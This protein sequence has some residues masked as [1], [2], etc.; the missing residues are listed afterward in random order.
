MF[1]KI[2][3]F[4]LRPFANPL[5]YGALKVMKRLRR[6]DDPRPA[7]AAA[8][9]LLHTLVIPWVFDL[10]HDD[11]FRTLARFAKLP[12]LEHDRILNEIEVAGICVPVFYLRAVKSLVRLEDYHFWQ[13]V[14][15]LL[16]K[17]LQETLVGYGVKPAA[18]KLMRELIGMRQ[19]EYEGLAAHARDYHERRIKEFRELPAEMK[20]FALLVQA[21][22]FG[23]VRHIRRGTM[24]KDDPLVSYFVDWL[25]RLRRKTS[26]LVKNL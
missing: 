6:R 25:M 2:V 5:R 13:D 11:R 8:D 24:G 21:T 26:K 3:K 14:E 18:A 19:E 12:V 15:T 23:T 9:H 16:P 7:T 22:A 20:Q 10:F 17:K 4:F 1:S